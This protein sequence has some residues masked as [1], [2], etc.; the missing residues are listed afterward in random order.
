MPVSGKNNARS[1]NGVNFQPNRNKSTVR[2]SIVISA[3]PAVSIFRF[4]CTRR[5]QIARVKR[6]N[7]VGKYR[8]RW[9]ISA[10]SGLIP[11]YPWNN[12][13]NHRKIILPES[14]ITGNLENFFFAKEKKVQ[15]VELITSQ[16]SP[17]EISGI[18]MNPV[19]I[20][21]KN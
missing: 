17:F 2:I 19:F 20:S 16:M 7:T 3:I 12:F 14:R 5:N 6:D 11:K 10:F 18:A 15:L 4:V 1:V 9:I 21:E 8:L 13:R